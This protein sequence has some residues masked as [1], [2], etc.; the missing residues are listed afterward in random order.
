MSRT[1]GFMSECD[2]SVTDGGKEEYQRIEWPAQA[3]SIRALSGIR[4]RVEAT[5]TGMRLALTTGRRYGD[6]FASFALRQR[7]PLPI[8]RRPVRVERRVDDVLQRGARVG[9]A[10]HVLERLGEEEP[11]RGALRVVGERLAQV[12][13][14]LLVAAAEQ[15]RHL[16]V[17][18]AERAIGGAR[19]V[20]RRR[21]AAPPRA[22]ALIAL[23]YLRPWLI[24]ND[25]ASAPM[26]AASQKCPSGFAGCS[27]IAVRA[28][29]MPGVER[30][31][32][33]RRRG[34]F[35]PR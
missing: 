33:L 12:L 3:P 11:A 4:P 28:A 27:A 1:V 8:L 32:A 15:A 30:G 5:T 6:S 31:A 19:L 10:A 29:A 2:G 13:L 14:R 24:P 21:G 23:R 17:P 9:L 26:L 25:S 18:A 35:V 34:P 7:L 22:P 20:A 16:V